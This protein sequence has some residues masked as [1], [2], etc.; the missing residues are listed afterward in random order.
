MQKICIYVNILPQ[1][2]FLVYSELLKT[3]FYG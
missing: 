2:V 1:K 3:K